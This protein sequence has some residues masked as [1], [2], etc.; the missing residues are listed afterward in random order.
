MV[1][2][3]CCKS[4]LSLL[5]CP[6]PPL[7]G[8][9]YCGLHVRVKN[10]RLWAVANKLEEKLELIVKI[11]RGYIVRKRIRLAGP[12]VLN[13]SKCINDEDVGTLDEKEKVHPFD[14]FGYEED[15]KLYWG[16]VKSMISILNSAIIPLNPYT[17]HEISNEARKRLREIYRYRIRN[18]LQVEYDTVNLDMLDAIR[19]RRWLQISQIIYEHDLGHIN[20]I[21]FEAL[22]RNDLGQFIT[23]I[24]EEIHPWAL[25][26]G[27]NPH[28]KR[29][30]YYTL[31]RYGIDRFYEITTTIQYSY[32]I[33]TVIMHMLMD[34]NENFDISFMILTAFYKL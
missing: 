8:S 34:S 1:S 15:G 17:R 3:F 25:A 20:P 7:N 24:L 21:H 33:S 6:N 9:L 2:C 27:S 18:K 12:G 23:C 31:L 5:R 28:S 10:P 13:R 11:W 30:K 29:Y 4:K 19:S 32:I 14:Y 16:D 22:S 26:H